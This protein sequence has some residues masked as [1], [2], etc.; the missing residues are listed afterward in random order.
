MK[1]ILL[2]LLF[3]LGVFS[4]QSQITVDNTL[5]VQQLI[6]D[7]LVL[8]QCA[9]V[10][11]VTSS[12]NSNV[13]G[14]GFDS[15]GAFDGTTSTPAFPFDGG[16]I[17]A[18]NGIDMVPTG[19]PNQNGGNP[20]WL[21]DTDLDA[22]IQEPNN[23]NNATVIEFEFIPFVDQISFNYLLAS[24]EYPG[25]VCTFA[26]TFA[27]IL[28][29]PGISD[30][31]DYNHDANPN[32]P[33]VTLDLGGQNIA[34]I[35]GTNIPVSP[36]NIH[37]NPNC[38]AGTLGEFAVPQLFDGTNSDN[39]S[40]MYGGQ[41]VPLTASADVIPGQ[42]YNIKLVI[43]DRGDTILNSAVFLESESFDLGGID[44]GPD[45]TIANGTAPCEGDTVT[46]DAG[47]SAA[48]IQYFWAKDGNI[49]PGENSQT[50]E[51]TENGEYEVGIQIG[52][53]GTACFGVSNLVTVEFFPEPTFD[54][55]GT[56]NLCQ[57]DTTVL[58]GT[59]TNASVFTSINYQWFKD[60]VELTGETNPTLTVDDGGQYQ[61]IIDANA[62]DD[63]PN[64]FDVNLI[65]YQVALPIPPENCIGQGETVLVSPEFTGLTQ[66]EINQVSFNWSTGET[67]PTIELTQGQT[68]TLTTSFNGCDEVVTETFTF[69]NNPEVAISGSATIC[70]GDT[71]TLDATPS[72][73]ANLANADFSWTKDGNLL[74]G[75]TN[76]TLDITD[77]GLYEV[78]VDNNGCSTTS[79]FQVSLID[80]QVSLPTPSQTCIGAGETIEIVPS[81]TGLTQAEISQ[82][83]YSWSTGENTPTIELSQGQTVT[84]TTTF[85]GCDEVVTETF[86]FFNNPEVDI[87][88]ASVICSGDTNTLNATPMNLNDLQSPTYSWTRDG[89]AIPD[90]TPTIDITE[91]GVYEVTVDNN[92][93]VSTDQINIEMVDYTLDLGS[94]EN[95][96]T[97]D[98]GPQN[99]ITPTVTGLTSAQENQIL[100]TWS[101]G[102]TGETL[103]VSESGTFTL[104]TDVD[105]CIQTAQVNVSIV[106]TLD[107]VVSDAVKCPEDDVILETG[108]PENDPNISYSW[109][110]DGSPVGDNSPNVTASQEGTYV[111]TVSNQGCEST[112]SAEVSNYNVDNCVITQGISPDQDGFN[113]CMD[114]TWLNDQLGI[115]RFQVFNRYGRKVFDEAN[116]T[117]SFCGQDEDGDELSTGTYFYVINLADSDQRFERVV[118][119]WV[120]IN[121]EQ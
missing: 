50:L 80:Y 111:V 87:A 4:A 45:I 44:L 47:F 25:F 34:V 48:N 17:L 35:P 75:E 95:L 31:N 42:T 92:G 7:V 26:D 68:V 121:L 118:K 19:L 79:Q 37:T 81:F 70:Q 101:D 11:N 49:I 52:A 83:S 93:C 29:G 94:D 108:L 30:V 46:L 66:D 53:G 3:G 113:D 78:T 22:L 9:E 61:V 76:A 96:C 24:D 12:M 107:V 102:S 77:G 38:G 73:N 59:P 39:G 106:E 89:T 84:L 57:G 62:C 82:V 32:T 5:T 1:R 100:Y 63:V 23:T 90:D 91:G 51:V 10:N 86:T 58:D 103:T 18:T 55:T 116:Y 43:A 36:V 117:D 97:G 14:L 6:D 8:G 69:F 21:G 72:N 109:T 2:L 115:D 104:E 16:I 60:G 54:P 88:G 67:T 33:D 15:F 65:D 98:G 40:T 119:G 41:T 64:T 56:I 13:A 74:T 105:G 28:N 27:F 120:Y 114:L 71:N 110:L 85:S 112:A 99:I 20:P